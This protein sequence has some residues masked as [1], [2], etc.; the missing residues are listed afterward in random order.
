MVAIT[1]YVA[2][3]TVTHIQ[4]G[5]AYKDRFTLP[6]TPEPG[7]TVR[8]MFL[9]SSGAQVQDDVVGEIDGRYLEFR[10]AYDNVDTVPNGANFYVYLNNGGEDPDGEDMAF[11]GTVFRREHTFP[12]NPAI[13]LST[14]VR[15]FGDT[16]QRPAGAVGGKWRILVGRPRIFD[17]TEWFGLGDDHPNTVGPQYDFFSRYYMYFYQPF[18]ADTVEMSIS[19]TKKGPGTTIVTLCANS[20]GTS[21]LYV[22]FDGFDDTVS[23]GYGTDPDIGS[24]VLPSGALHP[25]IDPVD[26]E[27]PGDDGYGTYKIRYDDVTGKLGFYND[28]YTETIAEWTDGGSEVPHGKGYRYFGIGGNAGIINSG[29]QLAY[30]SAQGAV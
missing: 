20:A 10:T 7:S 30:I 17:N 9:D 1:K 21:Y 27:V 25:Q 23:L 15:Q 2:R 22:A 13:S 5:S 6:F 18:N 24:M 28:D 8:I 26:L 29:V 14:V 4:A 11:Y 12:D 16:F 3:K 19:A